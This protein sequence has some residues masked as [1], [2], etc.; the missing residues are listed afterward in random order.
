[1]KNFKLKQKTENILLN[2][3]NDDIVTKVFKM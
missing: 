3:N 1:M 2:I